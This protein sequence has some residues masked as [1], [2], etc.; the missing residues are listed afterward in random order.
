MTPQMESCFFMLGPLCC[1]AVVIL[2]QVGL[3]IL[4]KC[5][6]RLYGTA[7]ALPYGIRMPTI[8][9]YAKLT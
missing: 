6:T 2:R 9:P 1:R 8:K 5:P 7:L 4:L 3:G